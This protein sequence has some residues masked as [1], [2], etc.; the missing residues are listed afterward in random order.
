MSAR[1]SEAPLPELVLRAMKEADVPSVHAI[2]IR[3]CVDHS[4]GES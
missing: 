4:G 2:E 1:V 3:A